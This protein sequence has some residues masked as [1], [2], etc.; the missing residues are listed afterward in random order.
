MKQIS[1]SKKQVNVL[2]IDDDRT[3]DA[4]YQAF[5]CKLSEHK[6]C[7]FQV[8][9]IL[10][11][12][13]ESAVGSLASRE[14][15]LAL[16]DMIFA[17][18]QWLADRQLI[19][20]GIEQARIPVAL[21]SLDFSNEAAIAAMR[22]T[23]STLT[24]SRILGF[25]SY[26]R[27]VR[28]FCVDSNDRPLLIPL[29]KQEVSIWTN[30][31]SYALDL[32]LSWKP[33]VGSSVTFLHLTDTHFGRTHADLLNVAALSQ[34]SRENKLEA[35]CLAWT[36]DIADRAL[37]SDYEEAEKFLADLFSEGIVQRR[38]PCFV[39]PGNHDLCWP[40]ALSSRLSFEKLSPDNNGRER[41]GWKVLDVQGANA[42]L[43]KYGFQPYREFFERVVGVSAPDSSLSFRWLRQWRH[44]GF[45]VLEL[46]IESHVVESY[47]E[48]VDPTP[49]VSEGDFE[50]VTD[51]VWTTIRALPVDP[52]VCVIV[53]P[54]GR[55]P[56]RSAALSRRWEKLLGLI[57]GKGN[58][59]IILSGH[60]HRQFA[61]PRGK[62]LTVVG[63]PHDPSSDLDA[64]TLPGVGY[65]RL[66]N[67][68]SKDLKCKIVMVRQ[69]SGLDGK[70]HWR[71]LDIVT[72]KLNEHGD[73]TDV[74]EATVA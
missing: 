52:S 42:A 23:T 9:P 57:E 8:H 41:V 14:A 18:G 53:L 11:D 44:L 25:F 60:E 34:F 35:D 73:W 5:F 56:N 47:R 55:D 43:W 68:Q 13:P 36:G 62:I 61:G 10:P 51:V 54:H 31:L 1:D 22:E 29:D 15:D 33:I 3:R 28:R 49:F 39:V 20:R 58:P 26:S 74:K 27:A 46:P 66:T 2:V 50:R 7:P 16:L 32:D 38:A 30:I 48:Q 17:D 64:L 45:A 59:I 40:L 6:S 4:I 21:L 63:V 19:L 71:S 72:Y 37:P 69:S 65:I 70:V 67:L 12:S 24:R